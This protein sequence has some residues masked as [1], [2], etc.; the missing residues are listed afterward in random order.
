[1]IVLVRSMRYQPMSENIK[2]MFAT[3]ASKIS[4]NEKTG[5]LIFDGI[6]VVL[7]RSSIFYSFFKGMREL[8]GA[9]AYSVLSYIGSEHGRDFYDYLQREYQKN[10]KELKVEDIFNYAVNELPAVGWGKITIEDNGDEII[11]ESRE[12]LAVGRYYKERDE[13][14][15]MPVDAYFLGYFVGL[16]SEAK[17]CALK[18]EEIECVGKGDNRCLIRLRKK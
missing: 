14:S 12:G 7:A 18:G 3:Y 13:I 8:I 9:S 17:G 5:E 15:D 10:N 11:I 2:K 1:M 4:I 6:P 16:F